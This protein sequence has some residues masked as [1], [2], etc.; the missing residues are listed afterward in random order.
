MI[1]SCHLI[2][3]GLDCGM[4]FDQPLL[5]PLNIWQ[6]V[7]GTNYKFAPF[8]NNKR[9]ERGNPQSSIEKVF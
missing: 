4:R 8:D 5:L 3:L 7:G 9:A 6:R 1:L 2:W